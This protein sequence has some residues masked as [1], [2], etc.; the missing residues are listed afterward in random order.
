MP[1]LVS[2]QA[3]TIVQETLHWLDRNHRIELMAVV[4]MPD[5]VHFV[6]TLLQGTLAQLMH[7]LK[8]NSA[9]RIN[10]ELHGQRHI[11]QPGYHDHALRAEEDLSTVVGYCLRNPQ[12]AGLVE[13]FRD[14][15]HAWCKWPL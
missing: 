4:V 15:P 13:D 12:R 14:Y 5:H 7:S 10:R 2:P 1:H 11:W 9:Q 8:S 3:A 6:A